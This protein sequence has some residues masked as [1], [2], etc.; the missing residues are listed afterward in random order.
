VG[1][2]SVGL[3]GFPNSSTVISID[4]GDFASSRDGITSRTTTLLEVPMANISRVEVTKVP[5]PDASASGL[6][7]SINIISRR[8]FEAK[9]PQFDYS[10]YTQFLNETGL[11]LDTVRRNHIP[12]TSPKWIEPSATFSYLRPISPSLSFTVGGSRTWRVKEMDDG[13]NYTDETSTWDLIGAANGGTAANPKPIQTSGL[14]QDLAQV[15][16]T[17]SFNAGADWRITPNDTA[18]VTFTYRDTYNATTRSYFNVNYGAG[19]IGNSSYTQGASTAVGTLTQGSN[20][21]W[22]RRTKSVNGVAKY[23]HTSGVW[24]FDMIG[25]ASKS[26]AVGRELEEGSFGVTPATISTLILRGSDRPA[27]GS[28]LMP[29]YSATL[30]D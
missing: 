11:R 24:R 19:A 10:V 16:K 12:Q 25:T 18:S 20:A 5:T 27:R 22:L 26:D 14:W 15:V 4:G 8:G 2:G 7:G 13:I 21:M 30:R 17:N 28:N 9:R 23:S 1:A 6:G 29:N 3:R